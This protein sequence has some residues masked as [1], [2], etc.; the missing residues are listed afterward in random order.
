MVIA[1]LIKHRALFKKKF[2]ERKK[3]TVRGGFTYSIDNIIHK[4]I[5]MATATLQ[6]DCQI[7]WFV[8]DFHCNFRP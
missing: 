6:L 8:L 3:K 7:F 2:K 1:V 4:D 5:R